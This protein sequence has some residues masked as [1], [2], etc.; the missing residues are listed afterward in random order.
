M[1]V[2]APL[3]LSY[4][5]WVAN[6]KTNSV[7]AVAKAVQSHALAAYNAAAALLATQDLTGQDLGQG[8][9]ELCQRSKKC[10][11]QRDECGQLND[12]REETNNCGTFGVKLRRI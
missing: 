6:G 12:K 1:A 7:N 4:P 5:P 11:V 2:Q 9:G 8:H 10:K 3:S